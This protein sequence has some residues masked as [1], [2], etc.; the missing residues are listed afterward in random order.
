MISIIAQA[1]ICVD[2]NDKRESDLSEIIVGL[3]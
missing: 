2:L 3:E 1:I